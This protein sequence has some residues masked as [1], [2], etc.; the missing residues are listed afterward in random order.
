MDGVAIVPSAEVASHSRPL[1]VVLAELDASVGSLLIQADAAAAETEPLA[2]ADHESSSEPSICTLQSNGGG[3]RY[4]HS[5][6]APSHVLQCSPLQTTI[7]AQLRAFEDFTSPG[8]ASSQ[9]PR[10]CDAASLSELGEGVRW[11]HNARALPCQHCGRLFFRSSLSLHE[12]R[13]CQRTA[14]EIVYCLKCGRE[15]PQAELSAHMV[16]CER[17]KEL[18]QDV[19]RSLDFRVNRMADKAAFRAP[20]IHVMIPACARASSVPATPPR[21]QQNRDDDSLAQE[22]TQPLAEEVTPQGKSVASWR[23]KRWHSRPQSASTPLQKQ[24]VSSDATLTKS[25]GVNPSGQLASLR[26]DIRRLC[27]DLGSFPQLNADS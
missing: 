26:G 24:A 13:C 12:K 4:D 11:V 20:R 3:Y 27:E 18:R 5:V 15:V 23:Q 22:S 16:R 2:R 10:S 7:D 1:A 25:A 6:I 19:K 14:W 9:V 8:S 21:R 17:A